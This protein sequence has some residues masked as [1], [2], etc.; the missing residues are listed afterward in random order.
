LNLGLNWQLYRN[1]LIK[2]NVLAEFVIEIGDVEAN[3][4]YCNG[5][6]VGICN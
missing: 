1:L 2:V 3:L 4:G 5:D 6:V